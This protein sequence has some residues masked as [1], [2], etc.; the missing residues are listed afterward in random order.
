M[1]V[2][3]VFLSHCVCGWGYG[4]LILK[5]YGAGYHLQLELEIAVAITDILYKRKLCKLSTSFWSAAA[6]NEGRSTLGCRPTVRTSSISD[7]TQILR[8]TE[9]GSLDFIICSRATVPVQEKQ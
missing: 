3:R 1:H 6:K 7:S 9:L 5:I 8:S 2:H 4:T